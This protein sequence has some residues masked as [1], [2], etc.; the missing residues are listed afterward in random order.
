MNSDLTNAIVENRE[1]LEKRLGD[2]G[3]ITEVNEIV[4]LVVQ[5]NLEVVKS[6][7]KKIRKGGG[8]A[9][10]IDHSLLLL[11]KTTSS[12]E[13][14]DLKKI[15]REQIVVLYMGSVETFLSDTIKTIG[16]IKPDFFKFREEK[17]NITFN[18]S[19]LQSNFTLGDA[20]LEHIENK[21]YSFQDLKS[22]LGVFS[23]YLDISLD[24]EE[25]KDPLILMAATRHIIVHNSS[26]VDRKFIKQIRDT[27]WSDLYGEDDP[28]EIDQIILDTMLIAVQQF[29]DTVVAAIIE[30]DDT[31]S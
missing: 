14:I 5:K 17:E 1:K 4:M 11:D 8:T 24:I 28:I 9:K 15:I 21:N 31:N 22:T 12:P 26:I 2:I 10:I 27:S 6:D 3:R 30:R 19:M 20:I 18:Q 16:N 29:A 23:H 7:L 25:L 13:I